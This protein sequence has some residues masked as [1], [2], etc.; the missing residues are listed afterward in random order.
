M[1]WS[2]FCASS[3]T[4]ARFL[5]LGAVAFLWSQGISAT[6]FL[7]AS[8]C[9]TGCCHFFSASIMRQLILSN[10]VKR[11]RGEEEEEEE[12]TFLLVEAPVVQN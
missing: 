9:V 6:E 4:C 11:G 10:G 1:M 12:T 8:F 2:P 7:F 5:C 3:I